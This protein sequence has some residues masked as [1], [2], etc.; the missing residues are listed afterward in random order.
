MEIS[1]VDEGYNLTTVVSTSA[2][3]DT[4]STI[5]DV[6]GIAEEASV[7]SMW[8]SKHPQGQPFPTT[9]TTLPKVSL[10]PSSASHV[11][12]V[13]IENSPES[14]S[15][16]DLVAESSSAPKASSQSNIPTIA[17]ISIGVS[18]GL[19]AIAL[20]SHVLRRRRGRLIDE[21]EN[22]IPSVPTDSKDDSETG[23]CQKAELEGRPHIIP[24]SE[25]DTHP[26]ALA[27]L[28]HPI[29]ELDTPARLPTELDAA[30]AS[31]VHVADSLQVLGQQPSTT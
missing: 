29:P 26:N 17:G 3:Q 10:D 28:A 20:V 7:E 24:K 19:A 4:T 5:S 12:T 8:S 6:K 27:E 31:T 22:A 13:F 14:A 15:S 23:L 11:S 1:L 2:D 25:L 9:S 30:T 18:L 16:S 21:T